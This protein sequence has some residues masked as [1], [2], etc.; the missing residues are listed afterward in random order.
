MQLFKT[1]FLGAAAEFPIDRQGRVLLPPLLR[2]F[3]TSEAVLLYRPDP[4]WIM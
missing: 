2:K 4:Q 1:F 3:L